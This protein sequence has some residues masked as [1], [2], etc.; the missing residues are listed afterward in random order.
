MSATVP[1]VSAGSVGR[2]SKLGKRS[3]RGKSSSGS[4]SGDSADGVNA[5]ENTPRIDK[6]GPNGS[7]AGLD[8]TLP[9]GPDLLEL[10]ADTSTSD[11]PQLVVANS[12]DHAAIF[13]FL[14]AV[15]QAP[16]HDDF[17]ASLD[18]PFYE[19]S[20]RLLVKLGHRILSHLLLNRR[21]LQFQSQRM[22]VS[23][24]SWL[25]TLPECRGYGYAQRLLR[26][27]EQL[28]VEDG[29]ALGMLRT[30]IPYFFRPAGW[31]VCGRHCHSQASARNLLAQLGTQI[32]E[33]RA[34][35]LRIRPWRQVELPALMRLY[36]ENTDRSV[37]TLERTEAYWRW[38]I[39]CKAFEQ[40]FVA[41]E[42]RDKSSINT[43][44][45]NIVGYAVTK[46][47]RVLELMT[48]RRHPTAAAQLLA[49]T[50]S[51][52]I[53]RDYHHIVMHGPPDH[54][55]HRTFFHAEG[56]R[57]H[58]EAHQGEVFMVKLLNPIQFLKD[59]C[60]ELH[61]RADAA[62][63]SRPCELGFLIEG[64]KYRIVLT[65]RNVKVEQ[66]R[67]GRSY[68]SCNHAEFA[69]MVLGHLDLEKA[70]RQ[71]R[72]ESSTRVALET[73][74]ILFPRLPLWRSPFDDLMI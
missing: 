46:E 10:T 50:C 73:G 22:P 54:P 47:D 4:C 7:A 21:T 62:R 53:E 40:I 55:L 19:P 30:K 65:R 1:P 17:T 68:L 32:S 41:I 59:I 74:C 24:V 49:R 63:L 57:L 5:R 28:M 26:L 15:F 6:G 34:P 29:S 35:A 11:R 2:A 38:L 14:T 23:V 3:G 60:C 58:H 20:D 52:A 70:V 64:E 27:A 18:D 42:G 51:E 45:A 8:L 43:A 44:G 56:H 33:R 12:G 36:R 37:G 72:L 61:R 39:S 71:G 9:D 31:A 69:R 48:A 13:Q 66:E 25:A 16:S 67:I